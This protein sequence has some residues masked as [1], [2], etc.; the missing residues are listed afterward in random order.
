MQTS[1]KA[2]VLISGEED[3]EIL[4]KNKKQVIRNWKRLHAPQVGNRAFLEFTYGN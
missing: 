4:S 2:K 1:Q 3:Q